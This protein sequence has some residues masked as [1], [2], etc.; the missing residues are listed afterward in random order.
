MNLIELDHLPVGLLERPASALHHVLSGP[1]LIHLQG[2]NPQPLFVTVL[3]HG[4]E[5][6]G[7]E[8]V[9]RLLKSH[10]EFDELPRSLSILI[11]NTHAAKYRLRRLDDQLDYNRCWPGGNHD[12][13]NIG[14]LFQQVTERMRSLSPIAAID[15][16]NN[17][18][19][20]PHYAAIN[21]I[22]PEFLHLASYFSSKVVFFKMPRGAQSLALSKFFPSTTL[23]CGQA[24]DVHGTDHCIGFLETCMHLSDI[25]TTPLDADDVHLFHMVATVCVHDD[26]LFGF[27]HVPTEIA[28]RENLD[29]LNFQELPTGISLGD[30]NGGP[31][32]PLVATD[33]DG[34]DV[35]SKYFRFDRRQIETI[36][37]I[38]P[39][40]LTLDRRVIQQDCLC[41]LMERIH[42]EDHIEVTDH[43]PLPEALRRSDRQGLP[44]L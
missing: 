4:N 34:A 10:Y 1:T 22:R 19:L 29:V 2:K 9:R 23:E 42:F 36:R 28:F 37:E 40:M 39:S 15:F 41:Y 12:D 25:P 27:G 32:W 8:A 30:V 26:V 33:I 24:G 35:T 6:T 43:D 13:S 31:E 21:R 3:Q 38:M 44:S 5:V 14:K 16:H 7:W 11:G 17:T 18:G 20:N